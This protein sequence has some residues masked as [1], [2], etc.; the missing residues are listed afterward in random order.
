MN[1]AL[2]PSGAWCTALAMHFQRHGHTVTLV[3]FTLEEALQLGIER[4]NPRLTNAPLDPNLQ[5]GHELAPALMEAE[6][7]VL[8]PPAAFFESSAQAV[9]AAVART[10]ARELRAVVSLT[11]GLVGE[12]RRRP[13]E[14]LAEVLPGYAPLALSGP[15]FAQEVAQGLPVALTLAGADAHGELLAHL[16]REFSGGNLRVYTSC[17]LAGVELG[18]CLK[19]IYAIA[20]GFCDGLGLGANAKAALLTRSLAEMLRLAMAFGARAETLYGLSGVGDLA[21]TCYGPLSRN[22]AFGEAM[23]R[24]ASPEMYF[25]EHDTTVEGYHACKHLHALCE[26]KGLDAPILREVHAALYTGKPLGEA[27][28]SLL[29]RDLKAEG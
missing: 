23:A 19:N 21:L 8:G 13:S 18:G 3:A 11:K 27:L 6:V 16:Q 7:L 5:I 15:S 28:G 20:G 10:E 9:K 14:V 22:R 17:D 24:G 25:R 4:A 2:Y 1:L 12:Q 26:A 29:A